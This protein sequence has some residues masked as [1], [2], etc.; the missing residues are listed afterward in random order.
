MVNIFLGRIP[1]AHHPFITTLVEGIIR[2]YELRRITGSRGRD[3]YEPYESDRAQEFDNIDIN[4]KKDFGVRVGST[5][6][7][8]N[9]GTTS[10]SFSLLFYDDDGASPFRL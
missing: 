3:G 1:Y 2:K 10:F 9:T 7:H 8:V 6:E 4:R 5:G